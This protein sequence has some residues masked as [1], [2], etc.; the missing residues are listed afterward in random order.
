LGVES[1]IRFAWEPKL[2]DGMPFP[3]SMTAMLGDMPAQLK[4]DFSGSLANGSMSVV[5]S[6]WTFCGPC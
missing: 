5:W 1:R 3:L 6:K 2:L 4:V